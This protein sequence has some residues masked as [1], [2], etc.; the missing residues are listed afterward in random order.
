MWVQISAREPTILTTISFCTVHPGK[1]PDLSQEDHGFLPHPS[2]Y[3]VTVMSLDAVYLK[4]SLNTPRRRRRIA[5]LSQPLPDI[6]VSVFLSLN[7]LFLEILSSA[8]FR[9]SSCNELY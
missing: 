6:V 3:S 7:G 5:L 9:K 4:S 8:V 1:Y 2:P